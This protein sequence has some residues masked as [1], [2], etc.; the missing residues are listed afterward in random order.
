MKDAASQPKSSVADA[1]ERGLTT[2]EIGRSVCAE[3]A[4]ALQEVI[5]LR[6]V[7]GTID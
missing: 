1:A 2:H 3:V 4:R 5:D 7:V 6:T